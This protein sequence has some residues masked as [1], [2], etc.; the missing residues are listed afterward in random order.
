MVTVKQSLIKNQ[1]FV[2]ILTGITVFFACTPEGGEKGSEIKPDT[3]ETSPVP[4]GMKR[5]QISI[6]A[7]PRIV[8]AHSL[9]GKKVL[10]NGLEYK[11]KKNK[12]SGYWYVDVSVSP[13]DV[14]SAQ[15]VEE[16]SAQWYG[17][18]ASSDIFLPTVQFLHRQADLAAIPLAAEYDAAR[19][20]YLY[21]RAP[22]AILDFEY[23]ASAA[24]SSLKLSSSSPLC[25]FVSWKR[26]DCSYHWGYST[27]EAVLNC[28]GEGE[29]TG[30]YPIL[31]YGADVKDAKVRVFTRAHTV[32]EMDLGTVE[33]TPGAVRSVRL[34]G[35]V[36]DNLLWAE[37]FDLCVWGGD[38]VGNRNGLA[39]VSE[40]TSLETVSGY[41]Y[42][43]TVV[44]PSFPGS[45][46]IQPAYSEET[47]VAQ[48]HSMTDSYII[49]RGFDDY[50]QLFRCRECPG[51]ISVGAGGTGRGA[52]TLAPY[53]MRG[54][55]V[56]VGN[57]EVSFRICLD[58]K[59]TDDAQVL[60]T[61]SSSVIR[62]WYLDGVAADAKALSQSGASAS[63]TLDWSLVGTGIWRT[64]KLII[65]NCT[66]ATLLQWRGRTTQSGNHAFYLDDISI[67][68]RPEGWRSEDCTR[69]LYWNI[70]NGMWADQYTYDN[71][72]SFVKRYDPDICVWC[73]GRS[74]RRSG[75]D[76]ITGAGED[77]LPD[78]WPQLAKRYG[79]DYVGVSRRGDEWFP[80]IVTSKYPVEKLLQMG[81]IPDQ[82]PIMHGAGIFKVN[83]YY[84]ATLHL[85][86]YKEMPEERLREITYIMQESVLSSRWPQDKGWL[87]MGDFNSD[88]ASETDLVHAHIKSHTELVDLI[89]ARYPGSHLST[90]YGASR[91]DYVYMDA[92]SYGRVR[93]A[94]VLTTQWTKPVFTGISNYY[95]PSDHRPVLVDIK[96]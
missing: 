41:D 63:L 22:Y 24:L 45:A 74:N 20:D 23:T 39:P 48:N 55:D 3:E 33:L 35:R 44:A 28:M 19:G 8:D 31:V 73:E 29:T 9:S 85:N 50:S 32:F 27:R 84:L 16:G 70:Q 21:F 2:A 67:K 43:R 60:V 51:Y 54:A 91:F 30:H 57:L 40:A 68:E 58:P 26:S 18:S 7:D 52:F 96:N 76:E 25:G 62:E 10:V 80:Q 72:V 69:I 61:G 66:D 78:G 83:G 37:S 36:E 1:L 65:D 71:F 77:Y 82:E 46:Y 42:A 64:V 87:V 86:P 5:F 88:E 94:G 4:E 47:A 56:T 34:D 12:K 15:L 81:D 79:H 93:D 49:S 11:P 6:D 17:R 14:Y 90:T 95:L 13:F 75:S 89:A 38:V 59:M 92:S 53:A